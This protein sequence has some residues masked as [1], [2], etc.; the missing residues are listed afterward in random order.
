MRTVPAYDGSMA[1]SERRIRAVGTGSAVGGAILLATFGV[2]ELVLGPAQDL[3]RGGA[4]DPARITFSISLVVCALAAIAIAL[5]CLGHVIQRPDE[6][7]WPGPVL[8]VAAAL[9]ALSGAMLALGWLIDWRPDV[10]LGVVNLPALA[11]LVVG[12]LAIGIRSW[13]TYGSAWRGLLPL[14]Q[15]A[16]AGILLVLAI[17]ESGLAALVELAFLIGW[18]VLARIIWSG[19]RSRLR[20]DADPTAS[21]AA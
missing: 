16:L 4:G 9:F 12:W 13:R 15:L 20:L 7:H 17:A 10:L 2:T 18:V 3:S 8:G 11:L 19:R 14:V 21:P 5:L 1:M 6:A